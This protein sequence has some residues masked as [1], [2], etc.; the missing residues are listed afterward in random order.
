MEAS[1]PVEA[2]LQAVKAYLEV[3]CEPHL[4][5]ALGSTSTPPECVGV[6]ACGQELVVLFHHYAA[7]RAMGKCVYMDKDRH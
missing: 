3:G 2:T 7:G 5:L 6:L 1:F 4:M